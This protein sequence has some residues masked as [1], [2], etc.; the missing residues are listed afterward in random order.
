MAEL[1][2]VKEMDVCDRRAELT[3]RVCA[4]AVRSVLL[5]LLDSNRLSNTAIYSQLTRKQK[6][7]LS[8]NSTNASYIISAT[9]I[10]RTSIAN[11]GPR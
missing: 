6:A 7:E 8:V 4:T 3:S 11:S 2:S 1:C 5:A 9:A 10:V